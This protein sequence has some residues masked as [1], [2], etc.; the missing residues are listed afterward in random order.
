MTCTFFYEQL[1]V[2]N[3]ENCT[4]RL[5]TIFFVISIDKLQGEDFFILKIENRLRF[6]ANSHF[7][8]IF[9]FDILHLFFLCV[10]DQNATKHRFDLMKWLEGPKMKIEWLQYEDLWGFC[11]F[12][13]LKFYKSSII[14]APFDFTM[15][16]IDKIILFNTTTSIQ[17]YRFF[18]QIQLGHAQYRLF[19][20]LFMLFINIFR[21]WHA[22]WCENPY[23]SRAPC[24]LEKETWYLQSQLES[25]VKKVVELIRI[26]LILLRVYDPFINFLVH[27]DSCHLRSFSMRGV[28]LKKHMFDHL[29][30]YGSLYGYACAWWWHSFT[31]KI[32]SY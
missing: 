7:H 15:D 10:H 22:S 23:K 32:L 9:F 11:V 6:E 27:S 13:Y 21:W 16:K 3:I 31:I 19:Q 28:T 4:Y 30:F 12:N 20:N 18:Y 5:L 29:I 14:L 25:W 24:E 26:T 1:S 2:E 8:A 17:F